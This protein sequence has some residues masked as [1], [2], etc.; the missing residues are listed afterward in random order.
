MAQTTG[1]KFMA[2]ALKAYGV[3]HVFVAPAIAREALAE[4]SQ[5]GV[6]SIVTHGEKAAAYMADGYARAA[7][8]PGICFAQSVG[9]ANLAAGLQDAYLGLSPV[10]AMTGRKTPM[11]QHKNAYQEIEH[12]KPFASVTK[13]SGSVERVEQ[14]P[15]LLRQAFREATSGAPGP[16]HLD[17]QGMTGNVIL[18]SEADLELVVEDSFTSRPAFR[19]EASTDTVRRAAQVIS[20]A[21]RPVI[22]AGGGVTSSQAKGEVVELAEMLSIPVATSLNAKGTIPDNHPLSVGVV[23]SYS[24]WCANRVVCESD[25]VIYI[26]SH[27]GSQVTNEWRVPAVGTSVIQIDIDPSELGRSYPNEVSL[28]GDARATTR[29]LIEVLEPIG[30][31]TDWVSRAQELVR[32]WREEVAPRA[33]SESVPIIPERLCNE[34]SRFLPGNAV[35][36]ADTGHAGI[37]TGSMVDLNDPGQEYIRCAGSLGWGLSGALGAKCALPDRPVICFTGD[38]GLWYHIAELETAVRYNIPVVTVVNNNHGLLQ[39][40]R[41]DDRAYQAVP[42]ANSADLWEFNDVDLAKVADAMG[43]FG[44][45]VNQPGDIQEALERALASG[46]PAVVDVATDPQDSEAPI[47]WAP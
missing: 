5:L 33:N 38:G 26:G 1:A 2:E 3:T 4:L 42:G 17:L 6:K 43:A 28:H 7:N 12:S 14:L 44:I 30:S 34:L 23:G 11:E 13:F 41:G 36:V 15:H 24:R 29:K 25:L 19:P 16:V 47:P 46:R 8:R 32:E 45:R 20:R 35:L 21:Q 18:Q 22:V 37:W 27:T 31:R 9:A 39:D 40:K 10:I